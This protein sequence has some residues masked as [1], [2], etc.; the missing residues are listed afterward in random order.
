MV[1]AIDLC[2]CGEKT[3]VKNGYRKLKASENKLFS[4]AFR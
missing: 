1:I 2:G 4:R 3:E